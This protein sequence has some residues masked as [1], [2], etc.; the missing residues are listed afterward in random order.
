MCGPCGRLR[1]YRNGRAAGRI[2]SLRG[3][4]AHSCHG[5][6]NRIIYFNKKPFYQFVSVIIFSGGPSDGHPSR[7][8]CR[9]D[10]A[11]QLIVRFNVR[12]LKMSTGNSRNF[13]RFPFRRKNKPYFTNVSLG[14]PARIV[15]LLKL[16][17][18]VG[19]L[20]QTHSISFACRYRS[21]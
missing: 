18:I 17:T 14:M 19:R 16:A 4:V 7:S 13:D 15:R 2:L 11:T 1:C 20:S 8:G 5:P 21:I 12:Q 3:G 10:C 9:T 6:F